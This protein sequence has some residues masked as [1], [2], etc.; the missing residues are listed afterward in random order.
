MSM[1]GKRRQWFLHL[2]IAFLLLLGIFSC[3]I[4]GNENKA[5]M[6]KEKNMSTG[7]VSLDYSKDTSVMKDPGPAN[8]ERATFA[9]G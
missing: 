6:T 2:N 4:S 1:V 7:D 9:L 3:G 5:S 8:T